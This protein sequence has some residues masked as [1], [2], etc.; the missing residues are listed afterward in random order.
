[1]NKLLVPLLR[2]LVPPVVVMAGLLGVAPAPVAAS[3][4]SLDLASI[5][6]TP[7]LVVVA[8]TVAAAAPGRTAMLVDSWFT[9]PAPKPAVT[10]LGGLV[11]PGTVTSADWAPNVGE[12]YLVVASARPDGSIVTEPCTQTLADPAVLA[13]AERIFGS[14]SY[15]VAP[16]TRLPAQADWGLLPLIAIVL[17]VLLALSGLVFVVFLARR[18]TT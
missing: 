7:D 16:P 2:L 10:I 11:Q 15:P 4:L 3:C 1:M 18:R 9:G 14:P 12:R 13:S 5:P 8:G 17:A 6:R